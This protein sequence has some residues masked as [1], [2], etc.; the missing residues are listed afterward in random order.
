MKQIRLR[1]ARYELRVENW[2]TRNLQPATTG[3][4]RK[5][6]EISHG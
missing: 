3:V 6:K 5:R 4:F 1:V 2:L